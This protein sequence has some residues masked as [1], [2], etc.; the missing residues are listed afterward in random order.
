MQPVNLL[1]YHGV[2]QQRLLQILPIHGHDAD[3]PRPAR[4]NRVALAILD[5]RIVYGAGTDAGR[6]E[7]VNVHQPAGRLGPADGL[8]S[9][10]DP[11]SEEGFPVGN[12]H[13][14]GLQVGGLSRSGMDP[15]NLEEGVLG[16]AQVEAVPVSLQVG[17][18]V[19]SQ[20]AGIVP[21]LL[22]GVHVL[23]PAHGAMADSQEQAQDR[24]VLTGDLP[25]DPGDVRRFA[26]D[27]EER[28]LVGGAVE[29]GDSY[30]GLIEKI[31]TRC[32]RCHWERT[33]LSPVEGEYSSVVPA[34]CARPSSRRRNS[35]P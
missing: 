23:G 33:S 24:H 32:D 10:R 12:I 16:V 27:G 7:G 4:T 21:V 3:L 6:I 28:D 18:G 9:L 15:R 25:V 26:E 13:N 17:G 20:P 19:A 2:E 35:C 22:P 29:S 8:Q 11:R 14:E 1:A 31:E 5:L 30:P 34:S